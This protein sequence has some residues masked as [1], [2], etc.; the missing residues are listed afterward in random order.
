[1]DVTVEPASSRVGPVDVTA[2]PAEGAE[3]VAISWKVTSAT[4]PSS[5]HFLV[6]VILVANGIVIFTH[7]TIPVLL[8]ER[9][10]HGVEK[11]IP[12]ICSCWTFH[13]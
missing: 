11:R 6:T 9:N 3:N 13:E 10:S 2:E 7:F 8:T 4:F 12:P 1:M 5:M